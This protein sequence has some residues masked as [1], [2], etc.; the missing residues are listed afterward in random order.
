MADSRIHMTMT[1]DEGRMWSALQKVTGGFRQ[2]ENAADRASKKSLKGFDKGIVSAGKFAA[3]IAGVGSAVGAIYLVARQLRAEYDHLVARQRTAAETH[4]TV[5]EA[6][7][8]ALYNLPTKFPRAQLEKMVTG[9]SAAYNVR[10]SD[11]WGGAKG[12]LSAMGNLTSRQFYAALGQGV[13][14]KAFMGADISEITGGAMDVMRITGGGARQSMGWLRQ[15]GQQMRVTELPEQIRSIVPAIGAAKQLGATPETAAEL[16]AYSTQFSSDIS[17]RQSM[18]GGIKF[19]EALATGKIIPER[20]AGIG[21]R[22]TTR[23]RRLKA[24]TFKGRLAELQDWFAGA[25]PEEKKDFIGK[26]PGRVRVKGAFLSL[27]AREEKGVS[28]YRGVQAAIG[29]PLAA[30]NAAVWE[31]AFADIGTGRTEP[32]R[33]IKRLADQ[34]IQDVQLA[35][36]EAIAGQGRESLKA[37]MKAIPGVSDLAVKFAGADFELDTGFGARDVH[38]AMARAL[39]AVRAR[40]GYGMPLKTFSS[41]ASFSGGRSWT[42]YHRGPDEPGAEFAERNPNYNP[43]IAEKLDRLIDAFEAKAAVGE[44]GLPVK[45]VGD[46]RPTVPAVGAQ[47]EEAP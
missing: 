29:G 44:G 24:T 23:F 2:M 18:T 36:P 11:I 47:G 7:A 32:V 4:L 26:L 38:G 39:R 27:I 1:A 41:Q 20:R 22:M 3:A 45:I 31:Q 35:D 34:F 33:D 6:R 9:L 10:A 40:F 15:V 21:G 37:I 19:M 25:T 30:G 46:S 17:G 43:I 16:L 13:R 14:A 28:A 12:P 8:Q 42:T 5:G